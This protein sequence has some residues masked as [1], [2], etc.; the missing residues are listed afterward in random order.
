M[1]SRRFTVDLAKKKK[2]LDFILQMPKLH[3]PDAMKLAMFSDEDI[4][5]FGLRRFLQRALPGDTVKAMKA[6]LAGVPPATDRDQQHDQRKKRSV[7]ETVLVT[8][9]LSTTMDQLV[10]AAAKEPT[11][12]GSPP[13][14]ATPSQ[15]TTSS[16]SS[17]SSAMKRK[18]KQI[19]NRL[20]YSK[21]KARA[22]SPS[23][24]LDITPP[25]V[26]SNQLVTLANAAT[27]LAAAATTLA[28]AATTLFFSSD[29]AWALNANGTKRTPSARSVAKH[30]QVMPAVD[31]ILSA[32]NA[33]QQGALLRA[34]T[35]HPLM[36]SA[37]KMAH[38]KSSKEAACRTTK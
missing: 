21:K 5:D 37:R 10:A 26:N 28:T 30:R 34:V 17:S 14:M 20:Y 19:R 12:R 3:V 24:D 22:S 1:A 25:P 4:A 18:R 15:T 38:V 29:A 8:D 27:T 16:S 31:S 11:T 13:T 9:L 2:F 32:G 23:V 33:V 36:A 35:D 6:Q 7:D